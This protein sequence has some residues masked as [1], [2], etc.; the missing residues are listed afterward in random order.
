MSLFTRQTLFSSSYCKHCLERQNS[1]LLRLPHDKPYAAGRAPTETL[2]NP[3][4]GHS[5]CFTKALGMLTRPPSGCHY[6]RSAASHALC[7]RPPGQGPRPSQ[8]ASAVQQKRLPWCLVTNVPTQ[9]D[10]HRAKDQAWI[11]TP[12]PLPGGYILSAPA[13]CRK[14]RPLAGAEDVNLTVLIMR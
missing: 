13:C 8:R 5:L 9:V 7:E 1:L 6:A 2:P 12:S 14:R 10:R 11:L 4:V 3:Q